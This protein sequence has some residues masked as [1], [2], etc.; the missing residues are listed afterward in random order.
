MTGLELVLRLLARPYAK[1]V[2]SIIFA[3]GG[4]AKECDPFQL[5]EMRIAS[6]I[7]EKDHR[8]NE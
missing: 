5:F 2:S 6:E 8:R 4:A 7:R 3:G 1:G